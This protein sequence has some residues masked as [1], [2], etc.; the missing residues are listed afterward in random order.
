MSFTVH[1]SDLGGVDPPRFLNLIPPPLV[2]SQLVLKQTIFFL[3][4]WSQRALLWRDELL[5]ASPFGTI[6]W[7]F[8]KKKIVLNPFSKK[9]NGSDKTRPLRG[10][11]PHPLR[12]FSPLQIPS[13]PPS[14]DPNSNITAKAVM[15]ELGWR[16]WGKRVDRGGGENRGG[17]LG[18]EDR[19]GGPGQDFYL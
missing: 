6:C 17:L 12:P 11:V 14:S 7:L 3:K 18:W 9:T 15:G 4:K 10:L 19:V 16:G 8:L 1:T 5:R 2:F 13:P